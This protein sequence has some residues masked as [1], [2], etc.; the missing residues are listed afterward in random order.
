ME[1]INLQKEYKLA[2]GSP[3]DINEH[4]PTLYEYAKRCSHITEMG[5]RHGASTRAFLYADPEKYVAY[6][7]IIDEEVNSLFN[8]CKS[9]GKDY[10]YL[11]EDVLKIEIEETDL[12]FI[13][14][15]HCYE[16]L[17]EELKLHSSKVKKYI[18][19]HD[20]VSYARVGENLPYLGFEGLKGIMYAIEEFLESNSEWQ[21]V[22]NAKYNNGLMI[23]ER[24]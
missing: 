4:L 2:T 1:E 7:L 17:T 18:A 8:Y 11:Q 22:H 20:T 9:V 21:V 24:Q 12:L 3:S 6:D 13:D 16:Q 10:H 15:Y 5:V 19:F 23:I 14:T